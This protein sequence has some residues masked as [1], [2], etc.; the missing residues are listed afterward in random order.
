[1]E[2]LTIKLGEYENS[3]AIIVSHDMH[4]SVTFGDVI[5]KIKKVAHE[6][7]E[8]DDETTF[9]GLIDDECVYFPNEDRTSWSNAK[10]KYS[11]TEFEDFLRKR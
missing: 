9:Y 6:R 8:T 2:L 10:D 3:S 7:E 1:M 11:S 5:V 4:L